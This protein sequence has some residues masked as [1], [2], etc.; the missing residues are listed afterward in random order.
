[1]KTWKFRR[2]RECGGARYDFRG[3]AVRMILNRFLYSSIPNIQG[4]AHTAWW[5]RFF[6]SQNA[7]VEEVVQVGE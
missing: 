7:V 4:P 3:A 5:E 6:N 1:M 2:L